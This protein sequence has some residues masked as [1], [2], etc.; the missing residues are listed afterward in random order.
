M[1]VGISQ[2]LSR[3]FPNYVVQTVFK[4]LRL[5]FDTEFRLTPIL[6]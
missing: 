5:F 2:H 6:A 1:L 4:V 3:E